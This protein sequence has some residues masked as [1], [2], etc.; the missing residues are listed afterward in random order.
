[1]SSVQSHPNLYNL[2]APRSLAE[3]APRWATKI[4]DSY[5]LV[6]GFSRFAHL[7]VCSS[8]GDK[9]AVV[10]TDQPELI[11]LNMS[12]REDFISQFLADAQVRS[13]L[14]REA[15]YLLLT[16]T[17]GSVDEDGCFYPVPYPAI[18]G[19]GKLD[20]YA[21]GNVWVHLDLYAQLL[22]VG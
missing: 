1:V 16:R 19:S 3:S 2:F 6:F 7:F 4:A 8:L 17:I 11:P 21:R 5:P 10:V 15:D 9:F 20:T 12:T 18:G 22:G 13:F 14:F